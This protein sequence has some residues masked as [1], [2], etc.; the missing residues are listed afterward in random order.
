VR[1]VR[2]GG[3]LREVRG[4]LVNRGER[5]VEAPS[6]GWG[7]GMVLQGPGGGVI[8]GNVA[9]I[10]ARGPIAPGAGVPLVVPVYG[11]LA[12]LVGAR[13]RGAEVSVIG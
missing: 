2:S 4:T 5:E 6:F 7:G 10:D 1:L 11:S 3:R 13:A 8:A 9:S 12:D